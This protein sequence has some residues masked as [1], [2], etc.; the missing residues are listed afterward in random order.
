MSA[1]CQKRTLLRTD[2][3]EA[4]NQSLSSIVCS[5]GRHRAEAF[6]DV[7]HPG[8][9]FASQDRFAHQLGQGYLL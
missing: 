5:P 8:A 6:S 4:G 3:A 2:L 1:L 9:I 7:A